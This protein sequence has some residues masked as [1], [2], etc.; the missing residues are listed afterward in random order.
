MSKRQK[1]VECV[2][3]Y[4]LLEKEMSSY[5]Q[6]VHTLGRALDLRDRV[7]DYK[8]DHTASELALSFVGYHLK[9]GT[10]EGFDYDELG[11][12]IVWSAN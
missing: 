3:M 4:L 12:R 6:L 5:T 2:K 10:G 9:G 1:F 8:T 11:P 7:F